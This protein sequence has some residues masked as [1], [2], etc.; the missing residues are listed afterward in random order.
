MQSLSF[1]ITECQYVTEVYIKG[2]FPI[3]SEFLKL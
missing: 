2:A 3:S 1:S